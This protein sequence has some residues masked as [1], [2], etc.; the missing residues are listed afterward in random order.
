LAAG[1]TAVGGTIAASGLPETSAAEAAPKGAA[2]LESL[3][4]MLA[5]LKLKAEKT[6]S[7]YDFAFA[8]KIDKE[9]E[10]ELSM[11]VVLSND[12]RTIWIMGW[13]DELPQSAVDV[14]RTALLRLL[15]D[16]DR[17]GNGHFFAYITENRRFTL[18]RVILNENIS[19]ELLKSLLI[20][21][22][23][24]VANFHPHWSVANWKQLGT[25]TTADAAPAT[26]A[27]AANSKT[28]APA[29]KAAAPSATA[30]KSTG[31]KR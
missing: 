31:V 6:E 8:S 15:A 11:S 1:L 17:I 9:D 16:N 22:G 28:T 27:P 18:Q 3:G 26:T 14:P 13:L 29:T 21:L 20:E 4:Q 30:T 23:K 10:W 19:T 24:N 12:T 5:A 7:R 2:T 25:S